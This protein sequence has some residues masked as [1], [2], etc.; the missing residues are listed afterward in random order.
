MTSTHLNYMIE[1]LHLEVAAIRK[2]GGTGQ[3]DLRGGEM[4]GVAEGNYLY[5][6]PISEDLQLRDETPVRVV[7][8]QS[9]VDG[10][11]VSI[12]K[13]FLIVA[14]EEDMGP[15]IASARLITDDS[16]LIERLREKLDEVSEG[17]QF[18]HGSANR[19]VG[20][21]P[22][23]CSVEEPDPQVF[24]GDLLNPGQQEAIRRSFGSDTTFI[25]GPPG[26][27]KTTTL[28]RI[29][30]AHFRAN[31]SVLL[32]SNTNIAV[33]TALEQIAKRLDGEPD[34]YA[35]AILRH[36]PVVKD[37]L[38]ERYGE[39]VILDKIVQRLGVELESQKQALTSELE[40][41]KIEAAKLGG[42]IEDLEDLE[43]LRS[44]L[45]HQA[46]TTESLRGH[47][48]ELI[49]KLN[50]KNAFVNKLDGDLI[51][52]REMGAIRRLLSGLNP[53]RLSGEIAKEKLDCG[54]IE[55][56]ISASRSTFGA[57]EL[58]VKVLKEQV[59]A[60]ESKAQNHPSIK[61]CRLRLR[62][63]EQSITELRGR[64]KAI[65]DQLDSLRQQILNNCR[66]LATT[67]YR[68]YLKGQVEREFDVVIIDEASMLMLP[69]C[70]YAAG[71]AKHFVVVAGDFRQLAPIVISD[72]SVALEWLK[73][74]AFEKTDIPTQIASNT[75]PAYVAVL[76][77]QYRMKETICSCINSI[78]YN[79][80]PLTTADK[81]R[82][83]SPDWFPFGDQQ[84]LYIDTS[85]LNPWAAMR[86]GTFS[87][88]NLLHALLIRK[89]VAYLDNE[90][91]L[92]V[93][94]G[95]NDVL[96]IIS[97]YSAQTKLIQALLND[98][99]QGR[100]AE[101][102]ATVHRFQGNEKDSI[103]VD[104][105]DSIGARLGRFMNAIRL[106]EDGS[107]LLNVAVSRARHRVLLIANF[108]FLRN[109]A[110]ED[111]KLLELLN[112]FEEFG[113]ALEAKELLLLGQDDWA[114]GIAHIGNA[115]GFGFSDEDVTVLTEG[116]FYPAFTRD[117]TEAKR[118][119]LIFSP[120]VTERGTSRWID[121]LRAALSREVLVR[122]VTRPPGDQ[123][124]VLEEGLPETVSGIRKLGIS[125]DHRARMHEKI[126]II[127]DEI[128]WHGSLN[129]LSH[130]NTSES[131]LRIHSPSACA[132]VGKFVTTPQSKRDRNANIYQAEN[133][134]CPNCEEPMIWKNGRYGV[135]FEC[136]VC[137]TKIDGRTSR[138]SG[139][140][141]P[142]PT[143]GQHRTRQHTQM[144]TQESKPCP[145]PACGGRLVIKRGPRGAFL[146]CTNYRSLGCRES[147]DLR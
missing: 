10:N 32:V 89:I 49:D 52:A 119:I 91:C 65:Q 62:A 129:V 64:L 53:D 88:Y 22:I 68:T 35:G 8:G 26:T 125:V 58:E 124:G 54:T 107:R 108:G 19:V 70:Y 46:L 11:I 69:M 44:D 73:K 90:G 82:H 38:R 63:K 104:L 80:H 48:N 115:G 87:R 116:T 113:E 100:G 126:A 127:D 59:S 120:F 94:R 25:W 55:S 50:A 18:N 29:V 93:E 30:E 140:R 61:E 60:A 2:R 1:A 34:F 37:E 51:R 78:F 4:I 122:L 135:Y 133:P 27:G 81:V 112:Y 41:V 83:R 117:L 23:K 47:L 111:G 110:P 39:E 128:L 3:T 103:I 132:Q 36:G 138:V 79:D 72:D 99:L 121:L 102:A 43:G 84:L 28:A 96:G 71:L 45:K 123:G 42:M 12:L 95:T 13:G 74:D 77:E 134:Q 6:F 56:G 146:G 15:K 130:N 7:C 75:R 141:V 9:E 98:Q 105:T 66:V 76:S 143:Q 136:D 86:L 139:T 31:R 118:S 131:M 16:F 147:E 92:P 144:A 5:R 17:A 109:K 145:R 85:Q 14:L 101:F 106:E 142:L 21:A 137:G 67:V 40:A 57:K 24:L 97:P 33:D 20:E 114:D